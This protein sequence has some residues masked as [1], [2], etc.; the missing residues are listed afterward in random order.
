VDA[1]TLKFDLSHSYKVEEEQTFSNITLNNPFAFWTALEL[2]M[3]SLSTNPAL[4]NTVWC[5]PLFIVDKGRRGIYDAV[6][7]GIVLVQSS[8]IHHR[9]VR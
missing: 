4:P 6:I 5:L 1:K 7:E 8:R 2:T 3:P 9:R